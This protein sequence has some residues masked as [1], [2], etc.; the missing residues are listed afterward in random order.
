MELW[1]GCVAGALSD[2]EFVSLLRD[3]GFESPSVELTRTYDVNDAKAFL[4]NT[5]LDADAI[6]REVAGRV[7]AAF[8][9]A[10]KPLSAAH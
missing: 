10:T 2:G 4:A 9:R 3:A 8:I 5:G 7:G 1:I 6:A